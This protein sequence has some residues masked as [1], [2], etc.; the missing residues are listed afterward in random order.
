MPKDFQLKTRRLVLRDFKL[1][2]V[3]AVQR[4]A[5]DADSV[6]FMPWGPNTPAQTLQFIKHARKYRLHH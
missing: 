2:D 5:S 4:Y 3:P 6:R 1:T